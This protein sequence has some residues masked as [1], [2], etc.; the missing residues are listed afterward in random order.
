ML[1][2]HQ[3]QKFKGRFARRTFFGDISFAAHFPSKS[4]NTIT[5]AEVD[6]YVI[7]SSVALRTEE[8]EVRYQVN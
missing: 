8:G 3:L 6:P 1:N 2:E 7:G 4:I 5:M